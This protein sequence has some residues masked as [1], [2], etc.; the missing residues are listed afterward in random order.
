VIRSWQK[1]LRDRRAVAVIEFAIILPVMVALSLGTFEA[2]RAVQAKMKASNAAQVI[3]D[4]I[5]AQNTVTAANLT[6]YCSGATLT[7]VPYDK[8]LLK[9][10]IASVTAGT[11]DW[12]D[13]SCGS[14]TAIASPTTLATTL[15]GGTGNSVIIVQTTYVYNATL[16]YFLPASITM[17]QTAFSHPRNT[18]TVT[19]N[20]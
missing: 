8:T 17:V 11:L 4:M 5:A 20:G 9:A 12:H 19:K 3:A 1:F 15:S 13:E 7:M 2:S 16:V 10:A 18:T 6:N 14:A